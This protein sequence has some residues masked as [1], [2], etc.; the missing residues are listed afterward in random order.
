MIEY[1]RIISA[2]EALS[3]RQKQDRYLDLSRQ[4]AEL[5]VLN[6][7]EFAELVLLRDILQRQAI[8]ELSTASH[9]AN[10]VTASNHR[11]T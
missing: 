6:Q 3:L 8:Y 9:D 1:A 2:V 11:T 4:V 10:V 5:R 7:D